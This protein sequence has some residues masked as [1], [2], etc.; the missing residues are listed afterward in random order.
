M[1]DYRFQPAVLRAPAGEVRFQLVN[2]GQEPHDLSMAD[3]S[4]IGIAKSEVLRSGGS[5]VLSVKLQPGAY[6]IYCGVAGHRERG[7]EGT[8]TAT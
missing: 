7:M 2:V 5:A 3:R 4:G 6:V 8:L 1:S